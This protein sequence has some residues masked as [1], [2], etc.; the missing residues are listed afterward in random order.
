M[1]LKVAVAV[2]VT[3]A[4][5]HTLWLCGCV[6]ILSVAG[7]IE[8]GH[9]STA[10]PPPPL[11]NP[12]MVSSVKGLSEVTITRASSVVL[13]TVVIIV[14]PLCILIAPLRQSVT[15]KLIVP[16]LIV[17]LALSGCWGATAPLSIASHTSALVIGLE[18]VKVVFV[19]PSVPPTHA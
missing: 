3:A 1:L 8:V 7:T 18:K 9:N 12:S 19:A 4:P 6:V 15:D 10:Y 16:Q 5:W 17:N 14:F 13:V 2:R 11:S